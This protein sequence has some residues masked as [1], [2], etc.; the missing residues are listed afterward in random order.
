[1]RK[2]QNIPEYSGIF[3]NILEFSHALFFLEVQKSQEKSRKVEIT[4][5]KSRKS[6]QLTFH[7]I[8]RLFSIFLQFLRLFGTFRDFSRFSRL[9]STFLRIS[10]FSFDFSRLFSISPDRHFKTEP[11]DIVAFC[12]GISENTVF[13][14][15]NDSVYH[16]VD[17]RGNMCQLAR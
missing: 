14:N 5:V 15:A 9:F 6:F 11:T 17:E 3:W 8:S 12:F 10:G 1:M 13:S 4:G 16:L 2:F 7:Y